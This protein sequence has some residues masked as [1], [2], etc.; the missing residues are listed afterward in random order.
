MRFQQPRRALSD[1]RMTGKIELYDVDLTPT[2]QIDGRRVPLESDPSVA[3]AYRLNDSWLWKF[4]IAGFRRTD[5]NLFEKKAEGALFFL[6]PY[7]PG[8]IPVVFVH[9]TASSPARWAEMG[10]E[11]LSDSNIASRYQFWYFIYNSGNPIAL[12]AM[13]L[14]ENLQAALKDLD[15]EGKDPALQKMVVIG[16]SQGGLLTKMTAVSSGTRFWNIISPE[17]FEKVKLSPEARDLLR[18]SVFVE[19]LPFVRRLIFIATPHH[20]SYM[21]EDFIGKIGR[22]FITLPATLSKTGV[23]LIKLNPAGAASAAWRIPTAID[24]MNWSNPFLRTLSSLPLAP[25][26]IAHS[27]IPVEGKVP[28]EN[29]KDGVVRYA[30]AHIDGVESELVVRSGHSCQSNPHTIEEVR[31]ILYEHQIN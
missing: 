26:V 20:G 3:I 2:A 23:E 30:S 18:R 10:N 22:W 31:R 1:G 9:G 6:T 11:L 5:F 28:A 19:P 13:H 12:S 24:N 4:E 29:G 25:G 15:P 16:H 8:R 27:I 7:R 14:R 17:P 21:A